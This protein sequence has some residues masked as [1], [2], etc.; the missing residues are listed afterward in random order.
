[1]QTTA[2]AT[3][4]TVASKKKEAPAAGFEVIREN[5]DEF[6][7]DWTRL[8][9]KKALYIWAKPDGSAMNRPTASRL[10][11]V[12]NVFT[13]R[14][15]EMTHSTQDVT[16]GIV[17]IFVDDRGGVAAASMEDIRSWVEGTLSQAAFLKKCSL[18]PP[19]AF[20]ETHPSAPA[21]HAQH[22]SARSRSSIASSGQF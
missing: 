10:Q 1:V 21:K 15:Q 2:A 11:F 19:G 20:G 7:G 13:E 12:Q 3:E 14:Y 17:V 8:K 16:E 22:S 5:T 4:T 18:D 9:G 6:L